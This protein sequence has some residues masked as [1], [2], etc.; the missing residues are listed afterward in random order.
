M[1]PFGGLPRPSTGAAPH[2]ERVATRQAAAPSRP[3]R[4]AG[5]AVLPQERTTARHGRGVGRQGSD[6]GGPC[7]SS[8][9]T[10]RRGDRGWRARGGTVARDNHAD[11]R[12]SATHAPPEFRT[13]ESR[14]R[15]PPPDPT[16]GC[17]GL[18][19]LGLGWGPL[20][21]AA[22]LWGAPRGAGGGPAPPAPPPRGPR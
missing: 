13:R 14:A 6:A 12:W 20:S 1:P 16:A 17:G 21:P 7:G 11:G 18:R 2:L 9:R 22:P 4:P 3:G 15:S 10:A 19:L 5:R 8:G